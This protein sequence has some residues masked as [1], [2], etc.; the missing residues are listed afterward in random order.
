MTEPREILAPAFPADDG[1]ADPRLA[2]ALARLAD[3]TGSYPDAV[4]ALV[5]ARLLV[6]VV[7][8]LGEVDEHGADKTSDMAT[9]LIRGADGRHALLAFSSMAT[10]RAWREDARPVP[11]AAADAAKAAVQEQAE[12]L[13]VDIAG[14]AKLVVEGDNLKALAAGWQLA[15]IAGS[16]GT[17]RAAWLRPAAG[18]PAVPDL[19]GDSSETE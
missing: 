4:A 19:G 7:A 16:D 10:L 1:A 15:A 8:V 3:G 14:P 18:P 12:A 6:P 13:L 11:V 5:Q 9:V 17:T 2:T